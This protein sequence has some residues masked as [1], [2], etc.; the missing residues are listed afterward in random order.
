A[1]ASQDTDSF[2]IEANYV[3]RLAYGV[4]GNFKAETGT[5]RDKRTDPSTSSRESTGPHA[6]G[7]ATFTAK[8]WVDWTLSTLIRD[9]RLSST[10]DRTGETTSDHNRQTDFTLSANFEVPGFDSWQVA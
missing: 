4:F 9:S 3:R 7:S 1:N 10:E 5:A 6:T 2:G 8:R